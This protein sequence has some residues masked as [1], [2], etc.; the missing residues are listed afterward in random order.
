MA[1]Y[2]HSDWTQEEFAERML[3]ATVPDNMDHI[4][5]GDFEV[6]LEAVYDRV[7]VQSQDWRPLRVRNEVP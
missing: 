5:L 2:E 4:P 3:G 1:I 7:S 6:G